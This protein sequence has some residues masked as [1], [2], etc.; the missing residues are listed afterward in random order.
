MEGKVWLVGAGPGDE[1]LL[2]LKARSVLMEADVIVY[3]H[4]V[5][6]NIIIKYGAGKELRDAG[7]TA[8]S[9]LKTVWE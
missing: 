4:L 2:T 3:D 7:K 6:K 1:G 8:I 9:S 5:G